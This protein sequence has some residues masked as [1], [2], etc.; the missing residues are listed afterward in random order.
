MGLD[1]DWK[2]G[3]IQSLLNDKDVETYA[4]TVKDLPKAD[5]ET[6]LKTLKTAQINEK[7]AALEK[8]LAAL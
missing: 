1:N 8:E 5:L 2:I 6:E 4:T 7:I 3:H